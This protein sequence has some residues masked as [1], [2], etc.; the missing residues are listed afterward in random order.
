L[1]LTPLVWWS[2]IQSGAIVQLYWRCQHDFIAIPV[3]FL[4]ISC[5]DRDDSI[6]RQARQLNTQRFAFPH[7]A[8]SHSELSV[9]GLASV[10]PFYFYI[11]GRRFP[12]S[13]QRIGM[14][15]RVDEMSRIKVR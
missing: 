11:L 7:L 5:V 4:A 13:T 1:G 9:G 8:I 14:S 3:C 6:Y 10:R 15:G 2:L 12:S